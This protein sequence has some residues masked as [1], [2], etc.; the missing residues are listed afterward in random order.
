MCNYLKLKENGK[1]EILDSQCPYTYF[2]TKVGAWRESKNFPR[3]CKVMEQIE[4]PKGYSKVCFEKR[5]KLYVNVDGVIRII[6]NPF[7]HVPQFVKAYQLK[8]GAWRVKK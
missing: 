8:S 5:G 4:I 7:D 6:P 1:C 2:C 3:R